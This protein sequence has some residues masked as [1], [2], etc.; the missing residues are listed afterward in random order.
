MFHSCELGNNS[1]HPLKAGNS[2]WSRLNLLSASCVISYTVHLSAV[3]TRVQGKA[4]HRGSA[5]TVQMV[6][7][8]TAV[9]FAAAVTRPWAFMSPKPNRVFIQA[10]AALR[11]HPQL[12]LR[13][14]Y[15]A[16]HMTRCCTSLHVSSGLQHRTSCLICPSFPK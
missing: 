15:S 1:S 5:D 3:L 11:C 9:Q 16:V 6:L 4:T 2:V 10:P 14:A 8:G 13:G 7:G 12:S